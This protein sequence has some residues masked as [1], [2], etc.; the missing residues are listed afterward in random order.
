[1]KEAA[2]NIDSYILQFSPEVQSLL[3]QMRTAITQAAP[4]AVE[5]ISYGMPAFRLHRNLVHFAAYKNHIGFYPGAGAIDFFSD[6]LKKF[7]TSK[8]TVQFPIYGPLPLKLIKDIVSF[9]VKQE[10]ERASL[11]VAKKPAPRKNDNTARR[12]QTR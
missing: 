6:K 11:K 4:T 10:E 1:M 9:Q 7:S 8:G 3:S 5:N 12:L 2:T